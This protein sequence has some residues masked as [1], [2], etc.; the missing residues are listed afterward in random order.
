MTKRKTRP[1]LV[2]LGGDAWCIPDLEPLLRPASEFTPHPQ[3]AR[4]GDVEGIAASIRDHGLYLP[5][6]RQTS[7]GYAVR[8]NHTGMA[9]LSL[10]AERVPFVDLDVPDDEALVILARDNRLSDVAG[11]DAERFTALLTALEDAGRLEDAGYSG[12]DLTAALDAAGRV[13]DEGEPIYTRK[14]DPIQ[15]VP[16]ADE[17]P[18]AHTLVDVDHR[19]ALRAAILED[20]GTGD[21]TTDEANF[22]LLGAERHLVFNYARIAEFYAHATPEVQ[23]HMEASALVIIDYEDAAHHGYLRLSERLRKI[24]EADTAERIATDGG[25]VNG[26]A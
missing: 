21:L 11:Y 16:V 26:G 10:G 20:V 15:Y 22:L 9:L 23:R 12:D 2:H 19:N 8:G 4:E 5:V 13:D 24:L 14:A 18:P 3:N 25:G 17:Q 1:G 6:T 7:T